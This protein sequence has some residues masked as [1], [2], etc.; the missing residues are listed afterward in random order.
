MENYGFIRVAAASPNIKVADCRYNASEIIKLIA[1][2]SDRGA[3]AIVFPEMAITAYT[4]GDLF[5][6][7]LL[8]EE[9][10]FALDNILTETQALDIISLVGMP[11]EIKN[12]LYNVAIIIHRG[13]IIGIVPKTFLPNYNEFYDQRWFTSSDE[14][15]E[16]A[17]EILGQSVSIGQ[18]IIFNT[19]KF[20]FAVEI[21]EDLW[22]PIPPSSHHALQGADVIFN[23]SASPD[24]VRK[25]TYRRDLIMNQSARCIAGYVYASAGAGESTTDLVFSGSCT[26][27]ENGGILAENERFNIESNLTFADIDIDRLRNDRRRNT[28]FKPNASVDY[29]SL[30]IHLANKMS[31][32][33]DRFV[34]PT[35]FI[36]YAENLNDACSEIFSIQINGLAKRLIHTNCKSVVLGISGGLDSTL[37]L[38]AVVKTFDKLNIDRKNIWGITMPGFGTTDRTYTNSLELMRSL[39]V[40]IKEISIVKSVNQHFDDIEHD[41]SIHDI[42]YEN[43]QARE[44]TQI[45]MDYANKVNGL[46][47]GTGDLSELALGWCTYNGDHM[48]MYAINTGIPKTLVK[49]LV[50]WVSDKYMDDASSNVLADILDT[51]ISPE[52]LPATKDGNIAQITEDHVGPYILHD[53]FLY[54]MLRFGFEPRKIYFLAQIAFKSEYSNE[55]ILKWLKVFYRR[56]FSQQF[57]RSCIPDGPKVGSINLSPRG[58]WRMPSDASSIIWTQQLDAMQ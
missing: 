25:H 32:Q 57:K 23:L 2:A 18:N 7:Q 49:V 8:L 46:V 27:A 58:D 42:T 35:P 19:N 26:I 51:P 15:Q 5:N 41:P 11:L 53:F 47:I 16:N 28:S 17:M 33:L 22:V 50:R 44:R 31:F 6:Q 12:Q 55:I 9:S 4:C 34:N 45:L 29:K 21:C 43:S 40:S 39:G 36:P 48:S 1:K 30:N 20:K 14:L 3:D 56:F 37:A 52:L 13:Q 24:T 38:L 10:L 54:N